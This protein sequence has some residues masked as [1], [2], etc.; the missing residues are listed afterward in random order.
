MK[1][2]GNTLRHSQEEPRGAKPLLEPEIS[3][4]RPRIT[5]LATLV[6]LFAVGA[7]AT[8]QRS[9]GRSNSDVITLEE[10]Q[11]SNVFNAYE[12]VRQLRPAWL[13]G[14]GPQTFTTDVSNTTTA[15]YPKMMVDDLPPRQLEALR[16]IRV[17]EI[18]EI[19]Y[20]N[21]RDA[22]FRYGTGYSGGII[23][24]ITKK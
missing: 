12:I 4:S 22:T 11:E 23:K 13:R 7:C 6:L 3:M 9:G 1:S 17:A 18:A 19:R 14:R 15:G 16:D 21:P 2:S 10:I 8:G 20:I 24:V 5:T